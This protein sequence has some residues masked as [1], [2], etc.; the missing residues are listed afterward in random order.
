LLLVL[1]SIQANEEEYEVRYGLVLEALWL[2]DTL[3][4]EAGFRFDPGEPEW[5]AAFVELPTG[6]V[7]WHM[8]Q[9]GAPWDGHSVAEKNRRIAAWIEPHYGGV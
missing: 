4:F 7:S 9:F 6:Q 1:R 2:A 3:G 5:P 8:P